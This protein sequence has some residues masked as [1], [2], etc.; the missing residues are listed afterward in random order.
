[1]LRGDGRMGLCTVGSG[2]WARSTEA[3]RDGGERDEGRAPI[4][5]RLGLMQDVAGRNERGEHLDNGTEGLAERDG[6]NR[7]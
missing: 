2:N 3:G 6:T 1:M 5:A 4:L 7:H